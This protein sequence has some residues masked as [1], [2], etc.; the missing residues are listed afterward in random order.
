MAQLST[1][2]S[3]RAFEFMKPEPMTVAQLKRELSTMPDDWVID[4]TIDG[5]EMEFYRSKVRCR[6]DIP[7]HSL[8]QFDFRSPLDATNHPSSKT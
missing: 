4:F 3:T 2:D 5:A 6:S 8:I 1:L 7:G